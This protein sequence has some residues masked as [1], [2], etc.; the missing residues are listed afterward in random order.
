M[1]GYIWSGFFLPKGTPEPIVRKLNDAT[2]AT[3]DTARVQD[4]LKELGV[5]LVAADRR[6]PD[7]LRK[8]VVSETEKWRGIIRASGISL[9]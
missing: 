6:S 2:V 7:Y 3:M 9:D 1:D 5:I 8:F 4:R